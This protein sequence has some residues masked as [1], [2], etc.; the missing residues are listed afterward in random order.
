MTA[1]ERWGQGDKLVKARWATSQVRMEQSEILEGIMDT[2][3]EV[4]AACGV[5]V[6]QRRL[7]VAEEASAAR[8]GKRHGAEFAKDLVPALD[9]CSFL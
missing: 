9:G 6:A 5:F 7:H 2:L 3:V 1:E 8:D 4:E